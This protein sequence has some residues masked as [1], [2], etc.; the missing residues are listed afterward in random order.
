MAGRVNKYV[1]AWNSH[2]ME[3]VLVIFIDE[4]LDYGK[5]A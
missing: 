2:D 3:I 4:G 5:S 1:N